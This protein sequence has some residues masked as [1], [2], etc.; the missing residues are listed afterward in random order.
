MLN[1][2]ALLK[3]GAALGYQIGT[4]IILSAADGQY[5]E[6]VQTVD[7]NR[8]T[9]SISM[10][11]KRGKL[12]G[13]QRFFTDTANTAWM[14]FGHNNTNDEFRINHGADL[15]T[16]AQYRDPTGWTHWV[17]AMDTREAVDKDRL[18]VYCNGLRVTDFLAEP[19]PGRNVDTQFNR[20]AT[21]QIG[22]NF[23]PEL[24]D[25]YISDF[26]FIDG[27]AIDPTEFGE[28][29]P[30]N[31][32]V[33]R[34]KD[35]ATIAMPGQSFRLQFGNPA[36]LGED[37]SGNGNDWA[38]HNGPKASQDS[39]TNNYATWNVLDK[40]NVTAANGN[41]TMT[42]NVPQLGGIRS[43]MP[44][45]QT[46]KYY[47]EMTV[48]TA[49]YITQIGLATAS[50]SMVQA[51]DVAATVSNRGWEFGSWFSSNNSGIT[52]YASDDGGATGTS[53]T[54]IST[55]S[56]ADVLMIAY[57]SDN[58]SLWFGTNGTWHNTSGTANPAT[59]TDP[60]FSGLN[61]GSEWF[62]VWSSYSTSSPSHTANFGQFGFV[63]TPPA[64]FLAL[65]SRNLP[66]PKVPDP[67]DGFVVKT[68]TADNL[69][70]ALA[71]SRAGWPAYVD[72]LKNRDASET[73]AWRFSHDAGNE[74]AVS[75]TSTHQ[76]NRALA[77]TQ[78]WVG[79][80]IR[81]DPVFGTAAGS[82]SHT[83]G[84]DTTVTHNLGSTNV[85]IFLFPRSNGG[86]PVYHPD[87]TAGHLVY[88]TGQD[89]ETRDSAIKNVT[90]NSFDIDTGEATG[91]YD[92]LVISKKT[93][94]YDFGAYTGNGSPDG[95]VLFAGG[96]TLL[97]ATKRINGYLGNW[98]I[99]DRVRS[100]SNVMNKLLY[101]ESANSEHPTGA[102]D[103]TSPGAKLRGT[104]SSQNTSG[105]KYIYLTV[106]D[107]SVGGQNTAPSNAV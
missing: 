21:W 3:P 54:G 67:Q 5:L 73:W 38:P 56:A 65:C 79:Y 30:V 75:T 32:N 45:P 74:Y 8:K 27:T 18:K 28:W 42:S 68:E 22:G 19:Y 84:A 87:L 35:T 47:W 62:P 11:V 39:P 99:L 14:M 41:L 26:T 63:H 59:N 60:R 46:G 101:F 50:K 15:R 6:R 58:G 51:N 96:R 61:D 48:N 25:G 70:A 94:L 40:G 76:P 12:L 7:G 92:Y 31:P 1:P 105:S 80:S 106:L 82:V 93:G 55:P 2:P 49:G 23:M 98:Y 53:W 72:I 71:L 81:I 13:N 9:F 107:A 36:N 103:A 83:N 88:L 95:P 37:S 57:D 64:G 34:P 89:T 77:G 44:I 29:D 66:D 4:S 78:K 85:M 20:A 97:V 43:T 33:W 86:V 90:S 10:W 24:F 91:T 17:V 104:D 16:K 69:V 100:P 52:H 102:V